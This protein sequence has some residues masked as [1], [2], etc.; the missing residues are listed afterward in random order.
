MVNRSVRTLARKGLE[1]LRTF[2]PGHTAW[3]GAAS[4]IW[5]LALA[6]AVTLAISE[7]LV[8][9]SLEKALAYLVIVGGLLLVGLLLRLGIW[10]FAALSPRYR[11]PLIG[12]LPFLLA[13]T[14]LGMSEVAGAALLLGT[15]VGLGL[16]GGA[17]AVLRERGP[18]HARAWCTWTAVVVGGG[19]LIAGG[20]TL[21]APK[22]PDNPGLAEF[23]LED[24]TLPVRD[25]ALPGEHAVTMLTYGSG[26][27]PRRVEYGAD[28]DLRAPTVDGSKLIDGW[29]GLAGWARTRYWGFDASAL[30]LQG[31]VWYPEG[32]GPFPLVLL[33]HGNHAMEDF[34]DVG[35]AYLGEL[36]ASRGTIFVSVDENFLNSSVANVVNPIDPGLDEENDARAW[37]LLEHLRLWR[38]WNRT[39]NH[40]FR[41]KVDLGRVA[42]IGHSRGGEAVATAATFNQ[43]AHYP[44]DATLLFDY[45]FDLRGV[46]AIAPVDGQYRPR[47][48][49]SPLR[50]VNYFVMHGSMDG[51]VTSFAGSRVYARA[52]VGSDDFRFKSSLYVVGANHGQF[53][54]GWG[55]CDT[56]PFLCWTLDT[57]GIIDGDDQRRVAKVYISA[58]LEVVLNEDLA[59]LPIFADARRAAAWVPDTFYV[60]NYADSRAIPIAD[61]EEDV[62]PATATLATA[63]ITAAHMSKWRESWVRLKSDVLESHAAILAWDERVSDE[64][65]SFA[66]S[67]P[68]TMSLDTDTAIAFSVSPTAEST[69]PDAWVDEGN[70]DGTTAAGVDADDTPQPLDWTIAVRDRNGR[71]AVLPLSHD[72]QLFPQIRART[73]RL[74]LMQRSAASELVFRRY[75]F[76]LSDFVRVN[77]ELDVSRLAELRFIFDRSPRGAIAL[78]DVSAVPLSSGAPVQ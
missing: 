65:A 6:F 53:N 33:V 3:R 69:L 39:S 13:I 14:L 28:V 10:L 48:R 40:H 8:R 52:Q 44:D 25:P 63:R 22:G 27:D 77:P 24:R 4:T 61:F 58:F 23:A 31:R 76:A 30:P 20:I 1:Q 71:R 66:I 46:V 45:G 35:Y 32:E 59:Y 60:A 34:S 9:F 47:G 26:R 75:R 12:L 37:L 72:L 51:D 18:R 43:L 29:D 16:V 68:E 7:V 38:T 62:D 50:G 36:L 64:P 11:A 67:L 21:F 74:L 2:A 49:R 56:L 41:A 57:R 70:E 73:S 78:D 55:R 54:T 15:L 17:G 42:L 5:L 19:I